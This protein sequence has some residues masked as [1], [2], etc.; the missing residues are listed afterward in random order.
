MAGL[1]FTPA[2]A[3]RTIM[4]I[5]DY[6]NGSVLQEQATVAAPGDAELAVLATLPTLSAALRSGAHQDPFAHAVTV[7]IAGTAGVLDLA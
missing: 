4:T 1:G 7:L 6:T 2:Q 3:L 5:S